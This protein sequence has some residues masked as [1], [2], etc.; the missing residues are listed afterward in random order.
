MKN[1]KMKKLISILVITGLMFSLGIT[2][3]SADDPAYEETSS[4]T[5]KKVEVVNGGAQ[6]TTFRNALNHDFSR[7]TVYSGSDKP[8]GIMT[9]E[10]EEAGKYYTTSRI[11]SMTDPRIFTMEVVIP[12]DGFTGIGTGDG[13]FN[14]QRITWRYDGALI[15]S[16]TWSHVTLVNASAVFDDES[17]PENIIVTANIR[18]NISGSSSDSWATYGGTDNRPYTP[19][20]NLT[21]CSS[22]LLQRT[23]DFEFSANYDGAIIGSTMIRSTVSDDFIKF[24]ELDAFAKD[25]IDTYGIDGGLFGS[26]GR[27]V[28]ME[29]LGETTEG[30]DI[31]SFVI[32]DSKSSVDEYL[33]VTKPLMNSNPA[34]LQDQLAGG[35]QKGVLFFNAIHGAETN[36]ASI[37]P[38]IL[39]RLVNFDTLRFTKRS[40]DDFERLFTTAPSNESFGGRRALGGAPEEVTLD[41]NAFLD[42]Y[43]VI[44]TIHSNPD[45][46]S[47]A[48]RTSAYGYDMNRDASYFSQPETR[49]VAKAF[50]KWDPVYMVEFH[51]WYP[52]YIIDGCTPPYEPNF[53]V[54][55]IENYLVRLCDAIGMS[56]IGTSPHK[57]YI[58]PARDVVY[59]WD[60]GSTIYT[61]PMSMLFGALG[62]TIEFPNITQDSTDAGVQGLLGLFKFCLEE[63]DGLMFNKIEFKRRGVENE[64]RKDV[65]DPCLTEYN[66]LVFEA[67]EQFNASFE[68]NRNSYRIGTENA[69]TGRPRGV[70]ANGNELPFFPEYYIIPVDKATQRSVGG[71]YEILDILSNCGGV[72]LERTKVD[73]TF[74]GVK[75]PAGSYIINMHQ[76]ARTFANTM[77]YDGYDA[78]IY[79]NLYDSMVISYPHLRGFDCIKVYNKGF[80]SGKTDSVSPLKIPTATFSGV[81]NYV[82]VKNDSADAV[83]LVNRLLGAGKEVYMINGYVK[84]AAIGDFVAKKGDV[85]EQAGPKD[86]MIFGE[87][88]LSLAGFAYGDAPPVNVKPVTKPSIGYVGGASVKYY[89][90]LYEFDNYGALSNAN[91]GRAGSNVYLISGSSPGGALATEISNSGI[92]T[93]LIGNSNANSIIAAAGDRPATIAVTGEALLRATYADSSL[94]IANMEKQPSVYIMNNGRYISYLPD[95]MKPLAVVGTGDDFFI[96]GKVYPRVNADAF[97]GK[98]MIAAGMYD[99]NG[100]GVPIT[101]ITNNVF[102][103][104]GS[105]LYYR[106]TSNAMFAYASGITDDYNLKLVSAVPSASVTKLTGN[107]NDLTIKITEKFSDGSTIVLSRTLKINNNAEGTY[108]VG[109]YEVYVDTKG[110]TQIRDCRIVN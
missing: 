2:T 106:I 91:T 14:P 28:R 53:E 99:N 3:Y 1:K 34:T 81:G 10:G 76:A 52:N 84:G 46:Y 41:V 109:G 94:I 60:N 63:R 47:R 13:E 86:N 80:F 6:Q 65:V 74:E 38:V 19:Y 88:A 59:G 103:K 18:F 101:L 56:A 17:N 105:Q 5:V 72:K 36:G 49:A 22:A 110:N 71:A 77:L 95:F 93:I 58:V 66:P 70:D 30:R 35:N 9:G 75:Y 90:D 51:N 29:S 79:P 44:L 55:L 40:D 67:R 4:L 108:Q 61:P 97:R 16:G 25:F 45:G 62:S 102:S 83:R 42:K 15:G 33:N 26:E 69:A 100:T 104:A 96:S 98:P 8:A 48:S 7:Y 23:G 89:L 21:N 39:D 11:A 87:T 73:V 78:S 20:H 27:Y 37:C 43:I 82:V 64:D 54:D 32:S 31:W 68:A 12:A 107:Q 50:T 57:R 85:L 24:E 92:G